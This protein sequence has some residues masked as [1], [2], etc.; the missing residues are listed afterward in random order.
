MLWRSPETFIAL[1]ALLLMSPRLGLRNSLGRFGAGLPSTP[2]FTL[3]CSVTLGQPGIPGRSV[4]LQ[5]GPVSPAGTS[6]LGAVDFLFYKFQTN[7]RTPQCVC[8]TNTVLCVQ[9]SRI[10]IYLLWTNHYFR[11]YEILKINLFVFMGGN[12]FIFDWSYTPSRIP[13]G[14]RSNTPKV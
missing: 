11:H 14:C 13:R 7:D 10:N 2:N 3:S 8:I 12:I 9:R 4:A 1:G 6:A 5:R